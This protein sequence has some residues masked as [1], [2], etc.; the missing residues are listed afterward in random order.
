MRRL[1]AIGAIFRTAARL[2]AEQDAT[3]NL[4]ALVILPMCKSGP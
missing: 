1:R 4:I 2:D 3:L